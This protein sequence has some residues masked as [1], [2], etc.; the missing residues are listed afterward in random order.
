MNEKVSALVDGELADEEAARVLVWMSEDSERA[1]TWDT[2]HLIGDALRG[3]LSPQ[4]A[5]RVSRRLANEPTILSP[6][7]HP[8]AAPRILARRMMQAAA[9]IAAFALVAW[10]ALPMWQGDSQPQIAQSQVPAVSEVQNYLLA[11]QRYSP[12]SAMQGV[13]P[14]VRLVATESA[15]GGK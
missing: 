15:G 10:M 8:A 12:S 4:V 3:H 6:R 5:D 13:A 7:R 14:Y 1:R 11:H 2:C 9:A